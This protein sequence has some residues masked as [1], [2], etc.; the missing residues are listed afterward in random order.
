MENTTKNNKIISEFMHPNWVH[1]KHNMGQNWE[2]SKEPVTPLLEMA[3]GSYSVMSH[4]LSEDYERFDYH[5]SWNMLMP[6]VDKI[7]TELY[8]IRIE[9]LLDMTTVKIFYNYDDENEISAGYNSEVNN[10]IKAYYQA[11]V[12]FIKSH[13]NKQEK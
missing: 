5:R 3:G 4:L 12:E 7:R 9:Y 13:N 6:V 8:E 10:N 2:K 11:V 1:P